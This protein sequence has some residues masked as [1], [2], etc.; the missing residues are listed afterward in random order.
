M[1]KYLFFFVAFGIASLGL[2]QQQ[3]DVEKDKKEVQAVIE[4]LFKGMYQADTAMI[5]ATFHPTA[6][7]QTVFTH[8][9]KKTPSLHTE[10]N[11]D[12]FLK[13]V[14]APHTEVYDERISAYEIRID[15]H[16]ATVWTPYQFYVGKTYSHSGVNAFHLIR[17]EAGKWQITQITDTRRK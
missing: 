6:R 13:S 17:N 10:L 14:A 1:I 12:G 9:V 7:M 5:R 11:I 3:S 15:E 8:K 16:M 4:Q 2:A